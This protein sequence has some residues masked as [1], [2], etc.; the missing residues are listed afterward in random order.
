MV[1]AFLV[2]AVIP[3]LTLA[4]ASV[5]LSSSSLEED[6]ALQEL[7]GGRVLICTPEGIKW[8]SWAEL[9]GQKKEPAADT[10]IDCVLCNLP[11][12]GTTV[13]AIS[14]DGGNPITFHPFERSPY[15]YADGTLFTGIVPSRNFLTRAPP[16]LLT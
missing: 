5:P 16:H 2:N 14:L 11:V 13:T 9:Q 3:S 15:A 8:V 12:F 10:E 4:A 1:L 6:S 7:L